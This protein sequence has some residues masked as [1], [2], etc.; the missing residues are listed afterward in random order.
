MIHHLISN[1]DMDKICIY[2]G[3]ELDG[4]KEMESNYVTKDCPG[5]GRSITIRNGFNE[6]G[7]GTVKG[8]KNIDERIKEET[9]KL[10]LNPRVH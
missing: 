5:C 8:S 7:N 9:R 4:T 2:C 6:T 10:F 3:A 1:G